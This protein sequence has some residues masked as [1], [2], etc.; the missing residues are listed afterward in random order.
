MTLLLL[1]HN[2]DYDWYSKGK[3]RLQRCIFRRLR[4]T[5]SDSADVTCCDRLFQTRAVS[6][7]P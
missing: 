2:S 7:I 6:Y 1:R 4:K 3:Q 5:D